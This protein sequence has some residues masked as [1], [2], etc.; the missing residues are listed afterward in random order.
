MVVIV[1]V[2]IKMEV[3]KL[4]YNGKT[5]GVR[6]NLKNIGVYADTSIELFRRLLNESRK[7]GNS[8]GNIHL[9][10]SKDIIVRFSDGMYISNQDER[11]VLEIEEFNA[12]YRLVFGELKNK[13]LI[14]G[15]EH[16]ETRGMHNKICEILQIL[17]SNPDMMFIYR[18][19]YYP[20]LQVD[21][22]FKMQRE[23]VNFIL[24]YYKSKDIDKIHINK[25]IKEL[26]RNSILSV[27]VDKYGVVG[28]LYCVEDFSVEPI[29]D[30]NLVRITG[31]FDL[32]D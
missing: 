12:L 26:S 11:Y 7:T 4:V 16:C 9:E 19:D 13:I 8:L 5:I 18:D 21:L 23:F 24:Y 14:L 29:V 22:A 10:Y 27:P 30:D 15:I 28:R 3:Q 20:K 32:E 25:E 2:G 6:L 31:V 1:K 17:S